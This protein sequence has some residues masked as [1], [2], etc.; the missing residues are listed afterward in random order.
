MPKIILT[1]GLP[2]SGKTT[3]AKEMAENNPNQY[4]NIC[5]DDLRA[6]FDNSKWSKENENFLLKVRNNLIIQSI[7]NGYNVIVSDTNLDTKHETEIKKIADDIGAEFEVKFFDVS[8]SECIRRDAL[9]ANHVGKKVIWDMY[10]RYLHKPE[11]EQEWIEE[12]GKP[13][14]LIVD[15]DGT[16]AHM[17]GRSPYDYS[18]VNTDICDIFVRDIVQKYYKDE[19]DILVVSGRKDNCREETQDWLFK[20][21]IPVKKLFMRISGDKREDSIVKR[22]IYENEI[23]PYWS[24]FFVLEDRPRVIRMWQSI[25]L[26]VF[27]CNDIGIDF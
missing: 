16:L 2:A 15:I 14:S 24:V 20:Q 6:M 4:K 17:N 21:D 12:Q 19:F 23:K 22:E 26:K 5:K 10:L 8:V 7:S 27:N 11:K 3:W 1:K 13:K 25:G 9:R 18:K